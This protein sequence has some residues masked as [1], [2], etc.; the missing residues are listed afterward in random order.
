MKN[1]FA[2]VQ[3]FGDKASSLMKALEN[4]PLP[5][6]TNQDALWVEASRLSCV[7]DKQSGEAHCEVVQN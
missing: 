6:G 2:T 7:S 4:A 1:K 5:N 3:V